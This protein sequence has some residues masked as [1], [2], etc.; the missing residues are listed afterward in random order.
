MQPDESIST[1]MV[2]PHPATFIPIPLAK[3]R[4]YVPAKQ[5]ESSSGPIEPIMDDRNFPTLAVKVPAY[6]PPIGTLNYLKKIKEAEVKRKEDTI[7]PMSTDEQMDHKKVNDTSPNPLMKSALP[8][9]PDSRKRRILTKKP[10]YTDLYDMNFDD[11]EKGAMVPTLDDDDG[12]G[13]S[14]V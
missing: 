10:S 2:E 3:K 4:N 1:L 8:W 12:D 9:H 11:C 5:R 6:C 14:S 7:T 13:D